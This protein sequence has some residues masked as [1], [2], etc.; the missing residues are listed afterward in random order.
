MTQPNFK[1]MLEVGEDFEVNVA[2]VFLMQYF[3]NYYLIPT[4]N[5]QIRNQ[6]AGGPRI[7]VDAKTSVI[8]PDFMLI[9]KTDPSDRLLVEA[10][11]KKNIFYLPTRQT[12]YAIETSKCVDYELAA[13]ITGSK[14]MYIIGNEE[15]RKIHIYES[16]QFTAHTF[17]NTFTYNK[18]VENRAF[19]QTSETVKGTW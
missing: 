7:H 13:A 2:Q 15:T 12:A 4:H 6:L 10:K 5:F 14:L 19:L 8:L 16:S 3:P 9:S 18:P 17:C 1:A 11:W